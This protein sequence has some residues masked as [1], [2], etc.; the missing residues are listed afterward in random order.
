MTTHTGVVKGW[1]GKLCLGKTRRRL[2]APLLDRGDP[3]LLL[4]A[5]LDAL[6]G[7]GG[8]Y[9]DLDLLAR[10]GLHLDHLRGGQ[11]REEQVK[12]RTKARTNNASDYGHRDAATLFLFP[13]RARETQG[14]PFNER[15]NRT[16]A[17]A[18]ATFDGVHALAQ[19]EG[20]KTPAR[21]SEARRRAEGE[22]WGAQLL[23]APSWQTRGLACT[24]EPVVSRELWKTARGGCRRRARGGRGAAIH[25]AVKARGDSRCREGELPSDPLLGG[26]YI[27]CARTFSCPRTRR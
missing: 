25:S 2:Y 18:S 22:R 10:Q 15:S 3:L 6:D 21:P 26:T 13:S 7:I 20:R 19:R 17:A 24:D 4:D 27:Q 14:V 5:L 8:L 1:Q 23:L 12:G 16:R 11:K 9:V